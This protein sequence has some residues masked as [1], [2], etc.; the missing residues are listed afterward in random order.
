MM[1]VGLLAD[2][3]SALIDLPRL[4]PV[5]NGPA[6]IS[7]M[8]VLLEAFPEAPFGGLVVDSELVVG[9]FEGEVGN[10]EDGFAFPGSL[11]LKEVGRVNFYVGVALLE[12]GVAASAHFGF[13]GCAA[14]DV[15]G[16]RFDELPRG[17]DA[18]AEH[19]LL[20]A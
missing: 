5:P 6:A 9:G 11:D 17:G 3:K 7:D 16:W 10:R 1:A 13:E 18:E 4:V 2:A 15:E 8:E 20:P 12:E 14:V 19:V